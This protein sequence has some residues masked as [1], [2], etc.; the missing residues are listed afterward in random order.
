[1]T[2]GAKTLS[3][4]SYSSSASLPP[5]ESPLVTEELKG[6]STYDVHTEG[7]EGIKA[8]PQI[9]KSLKF[10]DEFREGGGRVSKECEKL[11]DVVY[12]WSLTDPVA[13][14]VL[15]LAASSSSAATTRED[16]RIPQMDRCSRFGR[17]EF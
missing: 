17:A 6:R 2:T 16:L 8:I 9:F 5:E 14:S 1:M 11:A 7:G 3:S 4:S 10:A 12:E 13:L 15:T